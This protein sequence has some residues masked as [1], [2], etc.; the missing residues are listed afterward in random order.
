[1]N[2]FINKSKKENVEYDNIFFETSKEFFNY[3]R[4]GD[5]NKI[6]IFLTNNNI[7]NIKNEKEENILSTLL[8]SE[9]I[10]SENVKLYLLKLLI[11]YDLDIN[12]TNKYKQNGLHIAYKKKYYNIVKHLLSYQ[13]IKILEKDIFNKYPI[14]YLISYDLDNIKPAQELICN[15]K[16]ILISNLSDKEQKEKIRIITGELIIKINENNSFRLLQ[17]VLN[18]IA[19]SGN[20]KIIKNILSEFNKKLL[21]LPEPDVKLLSSEIINSITEKNI[22]IDNVKN[23]KINEKLLTYELQDLMDLE[24]LEINKKI[25]SST[26]I[27]LKYVNQINFITFL[28]SGLEQM[29]LIIAHNFDISELK[30]MDYMI[31]HKY[32]V[33]PRHPIINLKD[34]YFIQGKSYFLYFDSNDISDD[35]TF[36]QFV[37]NAIGLILPRDSLLV[38]YNFLE[39]DILETFK[40]I[41][42][43]PATF[44]YTPHILLILL[45]LQIAY[46]TKNSGEVI[47]FLLST[48]KRFRRTTAGGLR[49]FLYIYWEQI[50]YNLK[51]TQIE[52][53]HLIITLL[54]ISHAYDDSAGLRTNDILNVL[55]SINN[56]LDIFDSTNPDIPLPGTDQ[57][58]YST[59]RSLFL[60]FTYDYYIILNCLLSDDCNEKF[61][62]YK[63]KRVISDLLDIDSVMISL[64]SDTSLTIVDIDDIDNL[65]N[66]EEKTCF[67]GFKLN[68][69]ERL[70]K[71]IKN[72]IPGISTDNL[73][74]IQLLKMYYDENRDKVDIID[75]CQRIVFDFKWLCQIVGN[76]FK[77][78]D[79]KIQPY[80]NLNSYINGTDLNYIPNF[81]FNRGDLRNNNLLIF[82]LEELIPQDDDD[83][84]L[85]HNIITLIV[86]QRNVR[87]TFPKPDPTVPGP[88]IAP[89][90]SIDID[91]LSPKFKILLNS[92]KTLNLPNELIITL[93]L[94]TYLVHSK[95]IFLFIEL[96]K[97]M[98]LPNNYQLEQHSQPVGNKTSLLTQKTIGILYAYSLRLDYYG[99]TRMTD[100]KR[101]IISVPKK[102]DRPRPPEESKHDI[103]LSFGYYNYKLILKDPVSINKKLGYDPN[104]IIPMERHDV[105]ND[106]N[107]YKNTFSLIDAGYVNTLYLI[108]DELIKATDLCVIIFNNIKNHSTYLLPFIMKE[109]NNINQR[110]IKLFKVHNKEYKYLIEQLHKIFIYIENNL[111]GEHIKALDLDPPENETRPNIYNSIKIIDNIIEKWIK[112][113]NTFNKSNE[114]LDLSKIITELKEKILMFNNINYIKNPNEN[115]Y[116]SVIEDKYITIKGNYDILSP[117][118]EMI[119]E[120]QLVPMSIIDNNNILNL[121]IG[122][123]LKNNLKDIAEE[124]KN[125]YTS[126]SRSILSEYFKYVI[127]R[128]LTCFMNKILILNFD[129]GY[130]DLDI[131]SEHPIYRIQTTEIK[132]IF[133]MNCSSSL[134]MYYIIPEDY[135]NIVNDWD[136]NNSFYYQD[137]NIVYESL[138]LSKYLKENREIIKKLISQNNFYLLE[139]LDLNRIL[140]LENKIDIQ[141]YAKKVKIVKNEIVNDDIDFISLFYNKTIEIL[142][143]NNYPYHVELEKIYQEFIDDVRE[144]FNN[145]IKISYHN[146]YGTL[147]EE[148]TDNKL[149]T[150]IVNKYYKIES[151]DCILKKNSEIYTKAIELISNSLKKIISIFLRTFKENIFIIETN[152]Y[153]EIDLKYYLEII[154][155]VLKYPDE[156]PEINLD[157]ILQ[158][159]V[160]I[161]GETNTSVLELIKDTIIPHLKKVL[162]LVLEDFRSIFT[163]YTRLKINNAIYD[164]IISLFE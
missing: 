9:E 150:Y 140:S 87:Y 83:E 13:H 57:E 33:L 71:Y 146:K 82:L 134:N 94:E 37:Y 23:G 15:Q 43:S 118:Y 121:L 73:E 101:L 19:L 42:L 102:G 122:D 123:I 60:S 144:I 114:L 131:I 129:D 67:D 58:F 80:I 99:I 78:L 161:I 111:L 59:W 14:D 116:L 92:L 128:Q 32:A 84:K 8:E 2:K 104:E 39:D 55:R 53:P 108:K 40:G 27:I 34:N 66:N 115:C 147:I 85:I 70:E 91:L 51:D 119:I 158:K 163:N 48:I 148:I 143:N 17:S 109:F 52:L 153:D 20:L 127:H 7:V 164:Y 45:G 28:Y 103:N 120:P 68:K 54:T 47:D 124:N 135:Y 93:L 137:V 69:Y 160:S 46:N 110:I 95:Y 12:L 72:N 130:K 138:N 112:E 96:Y 117:H 3:V 30:K 155:A 86:T 100:S 76:A 50:L 105:R 113:L 154:Q 89:D 10:K 139:K 81:D 25:L 136:F 24:E 31:T 141:D 125:L 107:N 21:E 6:T 156:D 149:S 162:I 74:S 77:K 18:Y 145:D 64:T 16:N 88:F 4:S 79:P 5:T 157:T 26:E 106:T 75:R 38:N 56:T 35:M 36:I 142:Q 152:P 133:K 11:S 49:D 44:E 65:T 132:E 22:I 61:N 62:E 90:L 98:I 1:M 41:V 159:M 63:S 126:I 151:D 29:R 97:E